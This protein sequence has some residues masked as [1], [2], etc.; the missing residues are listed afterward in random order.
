MRL[1]KY[2]ALQESVKAEAVVLMTK[3][4]HTLASPFFSIR[5]S[6]ASGSER[7]ALKGIMEG[8][9]LTTAR[10]ADSSSVSIVLSLSG[11]LPEL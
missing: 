1:Q 2:H 4:S 8:A 5:I 9:T 6:A 7:G 11:R 3:A 10:G